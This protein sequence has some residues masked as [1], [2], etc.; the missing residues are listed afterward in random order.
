MVWE[1]RPG[2]GVTLPAGAGTL[3]F[4]MPADE[5]RDLPAPPRP[6][7]IA[8]G[9]ARRWRAAAMRSS[10]TPKP[11]GCTGCSSTPR[12]RRSTSSATWPSRAAGPAGA[13]RLTRIGIEAG[14]C[15]GAPSGAVPVVWD[16]VGLFGHPPCDV[17]S[18]LPGAARP[19]EVPPGDAVVEAW[20]AVAAREAVR[21][22]P[23]VAARCSSG[24]PRGGRRAVEGPSRAPQVGATSRESSTDPRR[25][26]VNPDGPPVRAERPC[27]DG[28]LCPMLGGKGR[29]DGPRPPNR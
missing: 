15:A 28:L 5:V 3:A 4:G 22:R 14:A 12:G 27:A 1:V 6:D 9:S 17:V 11:H 10:G 19:P 13:D 23:V 25:G 7:S 18:V 21:R 8:P 2:L 29:P 26:A 16:G 20:G 24:L